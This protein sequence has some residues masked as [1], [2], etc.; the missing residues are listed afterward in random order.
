VSELRPSSASPYTTA[1]DSTIHSSGLSSSSSHRG[2]R[3]S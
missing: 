3:P 2:D 1:L